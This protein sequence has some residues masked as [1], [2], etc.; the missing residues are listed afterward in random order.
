MRGQRLGRAACAALQ[1]G[2]ELHVDDER[3]RRLEVGKLVLRP[4]DLALALVLLEHLRDALEQLGEHLRP[5]QDVRELRELLP[6]VLEARQ[7]A[8][9]LRVVLH[10]PEHRHEEARLRV[11]RR[12][13]AHEHGTE[14]VPRVVCVDLEDDVAAHELVQE[15]EALLVAAAAQLEAMREPPLKGGERDEDGS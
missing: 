5:P 15:E 13:H 11:L 14:R 6:V 4:R 10:H 8:R 3:V 2:G 1:I 7:V 12:Q 9:E